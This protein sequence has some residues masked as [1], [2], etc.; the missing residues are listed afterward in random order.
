MCAGECGHGS[1]LLFI[2]FIE[3][4]AGNRLAGERLAL[5]HYVD[6]G[7]SIIGLCMLHDTSQQH[8]AQIGNGSVLLVGSDV[9]RSEL[10][11]TETN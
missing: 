7:Q 8:S 6:D 4:W 3:S 5:G 9:Q 1:L 2:L 11:F 10:V